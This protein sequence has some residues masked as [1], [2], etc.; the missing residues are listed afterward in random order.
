MNDL[1]AKNTWSFVPQKIGRWWD[2]K[3]TEIDIVAVDENSRSIIFG[4]CKYTNKETDVNV[5]YSLLEKIKKV[6]WNKD[7]R[8]EYFVFFS[9]NGYTE[10]FKELAEKNKN[11]IL[12]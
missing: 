5:Y 7:T 10:K 3:D 1:V 4:E 11:I 12:V 2:R 9:I 8:N 6:D